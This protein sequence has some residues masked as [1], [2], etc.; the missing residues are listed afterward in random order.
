M[1]NNLY[2]FIMAGGS[3]ERFW[4]ASR[5]ATPKHLLRLLGEQTLLEQTLRRFE[6]IVPWEQ[7]FVLTNAAQLAATR[8]A[9]GRELGPWQAHGV[10][11]VC[12]VDGEMAVDG[13]LERMHG[14]EAGPNFA[15]VNHECLFHLSGKVLNI[16]EFETQQALTDYCLETGQ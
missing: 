7:V 8:E 10:W 1:K 14:M 15:T 11:P 13:M 4:P 3:G 9:N 5:T 12:Y 2:V 6:G 16:A